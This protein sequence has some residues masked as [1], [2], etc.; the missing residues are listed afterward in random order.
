MAPANNT[1]TSGAPATDAVGQRAGRCSFLERLPAELRKDIFK[2]LLVN[3]DLETEAYLRRVQSVYDDNKGLGLSPAI[4][5]TCRKIYEE[6][7]DVLYRSNKFVVA[8][9]CDKLGH[10]R[11]LNHRYSFCQFPRE[12]DADVVPAFKRVKHWKVTLIRKAYTS[13][14]DAPAGFVNFCR[15]LTDSQVESL[16]ISVQREDKS[17]SKHLT[18]QYIAIK[19]ALEPLELLRNL[20]KLVIN[21]V[22]QEDNTVI[23]LPNAFSGPVSEEGYTIIPEFRKA[24]L[25]HLTQGSSPIFYVFKALKKLMTYAKA[26]ER[27]ACLKGQMQATYNIAK[28]NYDSHNFMLGTTNLHKQFRNHPVEKT[29]TYAILAARNNDGKVFTQARLAVMNYLESQYQRIVVAAEEMIDLVNTLTKQGVNDG[30]A[31]WTETHCFWTEAT[32]DKIM[33]VAY[34]Y[35]KAF[36]RDVP[37]DI[38]AY[39]KSNPVEFELEYALL[40]RDLAFRKLTNGAMSLIRHHRKLFMSL[41][42]EAVDDMHRQYLEIRRARLA[43]FDHDIIQYGCHVDKGLWRWEDEVLDWSIYSHWTEVYYPDG[44]E[45]ESN[46]D[47]SSIG[48]NPGYDADKSDIED[49]P[50]ADAGFTLKDEGPGPQPDDGDVSNDE[51]Q[52]DSSLHFIK[53]EYESF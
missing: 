28:C 9:F 18:H 47:D 43:L 19:I 30:N 1:D 51:P 15:A 27:N 20:P 40:P 46:V 31:F 25:Q 8:I 17:S 16:E 24:Y 44:Y 21:E 42:I 49:E 6:A 3:P 48:Y 32:C 22:D 45:S 4:L 37:G 41:I 29:L 13:L 53:S 7:S 12:Y 34:K 39:I 26:F 50:E 36:I 23:T 2:H 11:I 52:S 5:R 14:E 33:E 35:E 38:E 10:C